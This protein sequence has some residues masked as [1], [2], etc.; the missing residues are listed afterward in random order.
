MNILILSWRDIKHPLAGGAEQAVNEHCKFWIKSGH[1]VTWF[2][3]AFKDGSSK[4][5]VDGVTIVRKGHQLVGV[6]ISAIIWYLFSKHRKY[7]LVI[8]QFHGLPFFTPLFV[9]TKKL[10]I[11]Q[12]VAREV[13]LLNQLIFPFNWLVGGI[14][15]F[16]EPFFF[17]IYKNIHFMTSS[18][19]TKKD[20]LKL[21]M[22]AKNITII[23]HGVTIINDQKNK[24]AKIKTIIFLGALAKDKGIEDAIECFYLLSKMDKFRFWIVGKTSGKY[25]EYLKQKVEK[26]G[27]KKQVKFF[28]FVSQKKKFKLLGM[29]HV[30]VNPSARE[31]WGLVNIEAN[32]LQT[33]VVG[34][35]SPGLVDSISNG[36]SGFIC[37]INTPR[38]LADLT[39][40]I[41]SNN[42]LYK[43]IQDNAKLWSQN[44][45]WEASTKKSLKLINKILK[46]SI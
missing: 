34:Y 36:Y 44:Y 7:D 32:A 8:D 42:K 16:I 4:D 37:Q 39:F 12:E 6:Q 45:T 40:K 5:I 38:E 33:P 29:S 15:Y 26:F 9:R 23:P 27:I 22:P 3:S 24:K 14:G 2:S 13:W 31:G 43:K 28:G 18:L 41:I 30:L 1:S 20:L 35:R 21:K 17:T 11:I 25:F 19:S 46:K 10:V